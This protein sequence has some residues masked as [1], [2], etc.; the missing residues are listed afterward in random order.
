MSTC[1]HQK[2]INCQDC[3]LGKICLPVSLQSDDIVRLEEI[4]KRGKVLQKNELLYRS[5][6]TF[7]SVYVIRSGYIKTYC[8]TERGDEQITGFYYPGEIIGLDGIGKNFYVNNAKALDTT[9]VCEL[10]FDSFQQLSAQLPSL[11]SHFFQLMSQEITA[12]QQLIAM[13]AQ[14]TAEQK[15]A[16]FLVITSA[17]NVR[18]HLSGLHFD[19]PMS[20]TDIGNFLGLTIETVSRILTKLNKDGVVAIKNKDVQI[21]DINH[22]REI[23]NIDYEF[24]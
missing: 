24:V 16:T 22:L 17:R 4:V 12:D 13:L 15:V 7:R 10:P 23:A 18:R 5:Q 9:A 8:N 11:Q 19:L 2:N 1:V 3:R 6:D 14:K 21:N 20:R